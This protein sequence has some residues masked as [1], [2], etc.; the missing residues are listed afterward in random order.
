VTAGATIDVS[1]RI[2]IDI[3][4]RFLNY[5][6]VAMTPDPAG[7]AIRL[8]D[9]RAHEGRFGLRYLIGGGMM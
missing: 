3:G 5:G 4:Y 7:I 8:K 1:P 2:K 6:T 9:M